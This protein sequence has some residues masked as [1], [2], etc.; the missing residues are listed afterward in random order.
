MKRAV[1]QR[2]F[3]LVA[4]LAL[5]AVAGWQL[6]RDA[7]HRNANLTTLD[8]ATIRQVSLT[9][10]G[11]TALHYEKRGD[12]HWWHTDG[13]PRQVADDD[14]L[15]DLADIAAAQVLSWRPLSDFD[16]AR[17]GLSPPRA[18]LELDGHSLAFGVTAVTGPQRYVQVGQRIALVSARYMPRSPQIKITELH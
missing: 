13:T 4:V 9:L 11:A 10:P 15:N 14:R 2:V 5:V 17:I 1:R 18:V 8:P 16:P 7:S 6:Q 12:G 3:L